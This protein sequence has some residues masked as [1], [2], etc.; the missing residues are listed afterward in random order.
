MGNTWQ[1][2]EAKNKFSSLVERARKEGP[3][4]VTR[5]GRESV[6]V[7]SVEDYQEMTR[8]ESNLLDFFQRSPMAGTSLDVRRDR[9]LSREIDL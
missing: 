9:G 7:V 3:Q 6:V 2:Q 8:P 1:L 5:H 4:F